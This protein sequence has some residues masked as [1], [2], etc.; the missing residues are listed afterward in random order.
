[1]EKEVKKEQ[2]RNYHS[3]DFEVVEIEFEQNILQGGSGEALDY[4][5]EDY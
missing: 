2:E 5:G 4:Y 3:P 1:M